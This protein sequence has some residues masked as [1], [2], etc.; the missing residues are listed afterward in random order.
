[1]DAIIEI[2]TNVFSDIELNGIIDNI[3]GFLTEYDV[4]AAIDT[5]V[6]FFG[7]IFG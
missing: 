3:A 4:S 7:G 5:I 2:L 6:S 1:M